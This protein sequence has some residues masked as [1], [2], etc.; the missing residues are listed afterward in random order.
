MSQVHFRK[1]GAH[2]RLVPLLAPITPPFP[3]GSNSLKRAG[4][5]NGPILSFRFQVSGF[6]FQARG[7]WNLEFGNSLAATNLALSS[8]P[9]SPRPFS[10]ISPPIP[11]GSDFLRTRKGLAKPLPQPRG[12]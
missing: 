4:T 3:P 1:V 6:R 5:E 2:G 10:P 12:A 9:N 8:H 7:V 11:D